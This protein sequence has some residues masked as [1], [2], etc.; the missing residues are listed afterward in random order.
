MA[1]F[2]HETRRPRTIHPVPKPRRETPEQRLTRREGE[3]NDQAGV[4][5]DQ[6]MTA[7]ERG[8][9]AYSHR[10]LDRMHDLRTEYLDVIAAA[11]ETAGEESQVIYEL[12]PGAAVA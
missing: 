8:Q 10:V 9:R 4:L 6:L 12:G 11:Q 7:I 2:Y 1:S 3:L 5:Y